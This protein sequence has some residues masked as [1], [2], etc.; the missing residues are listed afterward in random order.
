MVRMTVCHV[1]KRRERRREK[2]R[3]PGGPCLSPLHGDGVSWSV[4]DCG[5]VDQ[6]EDQGD[7]LEEVGGPKT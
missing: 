5:Q 4:D 3:K 7:V 6:G 2:M 1:V